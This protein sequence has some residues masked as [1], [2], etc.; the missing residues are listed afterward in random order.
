MQN[1]K[2][3]ERKTTMASRQSW[4]WMLV[5]ALVITANGARGAEFQ[6]IGDLP[7]GPF[8]S[9]ARAIS[10]DGTTV[11]GASFSELSPTN[12][13]EAIIWT[14]ENGIEG[15]G[16]A[17]TPVP[18]IDDRVTSVAGSVNQ[19]GS[20]VGG[21][22]GLVTN[23]GSL[24]RNDPFVWKEDEGP[25]RVGLDSV[26]NGYRVTGV[27]EMSR[28]GSVLVGPATRPLGSNKVI[29]VVP[30]IWTEADG[31]RLL[32]ALQQ[33]NTQSFPAHMTYDGHTIVGTS[34]GTNLEGVRESEGWI[35]TR[36]TGMRGI[37]DLPGGR[38]DSKANDV[39]ADGRVVVGEGHSNEGTQPILWTESTGMLRLRQSNREK[40]LG[41]AN[42][43]SSD[44]KTVYGRGAYFQGEIQVFV[45]DAVYG[46]RPF[47]NYLIEQHGLGEALEG[48]RIVSVHG[49]SEDG[50][51]LIGN[52][53]NPSGNDEGWVAVLDDLPEPEIL[54]GD[55]DLDGAVSLSDYAILRE[56]FRSGGFR[57]EGDLDGDFDVDL[58]DFLLVTSNFGKVAAQV[59]EPRTWPL[60]AMAMIIWLGRR[61]RFTAAL[62][63][64]GMCGAWLTNAAHAQFEL[65][66][67]D[68]LSISIVNVGNTPV[69]IIGYELKTDPRRLQPEEWESIEQ[70]ARRD[71]PESV[72]EVIQQLGFGAMNLTEARGRTRS[73]AEVSF[74]IGPIFESGAAF[75]IG[76]PFAGTAEEILAQHPRFR[77]GQY[78][79]GESAEVF[80]ACLGLEV[81]EPLPPRVPGDV[82]GDGRIGLVEFTIL[83]DNFG[84]VFDHR[85]LNGDGYTDLFDWADLFNQAL[86][87]PGSVKLSDITLLKDYLGGEP[88]YAFGDAN[89]D[90]VVDLKDFI[91]LKSN[92]G[93]PQAAAVP[94]S[95][96]VLLLV[97]GLL[98]LPLF[99]RV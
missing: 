2:T 58:N 98:A 41:R 62:C 60:L 27:H 17:L 79:E 66:L 47:Q 83:K 65:R 56:H 10:P 51:T 90:G 38:V 73:L 14:K 64:A 94:E 93:N 13:G 21:F 49:V 72:F 30:Y 9:S 89:T 7:G 34:S 76:R 22:V 15:I 80:E 48:W 78:T 29:P 11:V 75:N 70:Q 12:L 87:D 24:I 25:V 42:V 92:V 19:D 44:G 37:G 4:K 81:C 95:A 32:G 96:S 1:G 35:W 40:I 85:D 69:T 20:M 97:A 68:D 74:A 28:D 5:V 53:I 86:E 71:P 36:Q 18:P 23:I 99:R 59:P 82:N 88:T 77:F 61:A 8:R 45:W 52:G 63:L 46:A 55:I 91:L 16:K 26:P 3:K 67:G 31:V 33:K 84:T 39:S 6:G 54:P 57:Y 50:R 43:I